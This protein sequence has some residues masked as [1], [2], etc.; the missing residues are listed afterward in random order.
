MRFADGTPLSIDN[1]PVTTAIRP[2]KATGPF[3]MIVRRS[4][5]SQIH[6]RTYCAPFSDG[7]GAVVTSEPLDVALAPEIGS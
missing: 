4:D 1:A 7:D 3:I 5:G 6:T 2:G